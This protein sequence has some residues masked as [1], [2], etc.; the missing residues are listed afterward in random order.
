M[1]K[2]SPRADVF[3]CSPISD[4]GASARHGMLKVHRFTRHVPGMSPRQAPCRA[5]WPQPAP[6][7]VRAEIMRPSSSATIAMMPTVTR[8][9][10]SMSAATKST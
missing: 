2:Y 10:F 7:L 6:A 3:R 9:A 5:S 8:L 1:A 4:I